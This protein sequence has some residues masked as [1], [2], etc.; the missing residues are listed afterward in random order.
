[1]YIYIPIPIHISVCVCVYFQ[2]KIFLSR[3][4][5]FLALSQFL[6]QLPYLH[7]RTQ[8]SLHARCKEADCRDAAQ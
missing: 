2:L 5:K 7:S 8:T 3:L 6:K 4:R 1:M